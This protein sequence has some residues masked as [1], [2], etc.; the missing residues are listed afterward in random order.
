V[1]RFIALLGLVGSLT[2]SPFI[3]RAAD[4]PDAKA[5]VEKAI[6]AVG[7]AAKLAKHSS[8]TWN[9]TGK[10]YG[11][12][13]GLDYEGKYV[14]QWPDKSRMEIP[15]V[16]TIVYAKDKGWVNSANS[17][18]NEL[19]ANELA[20]QGKNHRASWIAFRL[21]LADKNL[22]WTAT[23]ELKI[24]DRPTLGVKVSQP[25]QRDVTL[26]FDKE[27][28]LL[29]KSEYTVKSREHGNMEVKQ[30]VIYS[31]YQEI[32]GLKTPTKYSIKR[33][34]KLFVE[35]ERSEIKFPE[36]LDEGAFAKPE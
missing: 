15:G 6:K 17:G 24:D 22:K 14:L 3:S 29:T 16:F 27:T 34:G 20:E 33:D 23:G 4:A 35:G 10:Y 25:G 32:E 7:G 30:E 26:Y 21:P 18:T 1:T 2:F 13:D 5:T 9:E 31:G 19:D 8:M 12:G 11:M 36:K 28:G